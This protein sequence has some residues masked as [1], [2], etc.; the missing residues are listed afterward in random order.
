MVKIP[1]TSLLPAVGIYYLA[2]FSE[3]VNFG[4]DFIEYGFS[5]ASVNLITSSVNDK[6]KAIDTNFETSTH[7]NTAV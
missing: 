1:V 2:M 7:G 6:L 4:D 5:P 3:N